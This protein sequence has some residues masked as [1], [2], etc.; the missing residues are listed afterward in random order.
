VKSITGDFSKY[1]H[2]LSVKYFG[3][4]SVGVPSEAE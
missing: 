3:E 4:E 2:F 1:F